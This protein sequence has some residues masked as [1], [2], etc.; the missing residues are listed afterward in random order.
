MP[1]QGAIHEHNNIRR[2][3]I[4]SFLIENPVHMMEI[5][6][7]VEHTYIVLMKITYIISTEVYMLCGSRSFSTKIIGIDLSVA[8]H[9]L[10][11]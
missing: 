8:V 9:V 1:G 6:I 7:L 2:I 4:R 10:R 11:F 3:M 5:V